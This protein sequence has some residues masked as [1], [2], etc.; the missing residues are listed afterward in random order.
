MEK[1]RKNVIPNWYQKNKCPVKGQQILRGRATRE[2]WKKDG[3]GS[4]LKKSNG[5]ECWV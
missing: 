2:R 4:D 3:R 1:E 5:G